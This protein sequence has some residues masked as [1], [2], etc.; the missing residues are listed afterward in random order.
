MGS[1]GVAP[2]VGTFRRVALCVGGWS[3]IVG[4]SGRSIGAATVPMPPGV[5]G[6]RALIA[7]P[8]GM[9]E[10]RS[11]VVFDGADAEAALYAS[12]CSSRSRTSAALAVGV[13]EVSSPLPRSPTIVSEV[14]AGDPL[15][16]EIAK[17]KAD[18]AFWTSSDNEVSR[19]VADTLA[20]ASADG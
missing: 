20:I 1:I 11:E 14:S 7:S 18:N 16:A 19:K 8:P 6:V 2:T 9:E 4:P 13:A 17:L 15:P 10:V 5:N 3:G 12:V